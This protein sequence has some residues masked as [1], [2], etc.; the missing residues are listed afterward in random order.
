MKN[1]LLYLAVIGCF[2]F[3]SCETEDT[4]DVSQITNFAV[5]TLEGD[6]EI[7]L[8]VGE[9]YVEP[10]ATAL[11]AGEPVDVSVS[12]SGLFRG[13]ELDVTVPDI[14]S[15]NYSA[16][17]KDGFVATASRTVVVAENGDLVTDLSG[18]YRS[19]IVRN[20]TT[21]PQYTDIEYVLV[22]EKSPGVYQIS[23]A[24]GGYYMYGR[25]Y[26]IGYAAQGLEITVNGP[27]SY[28]FNDPIGVGAF[29]GDLTVT[30]LTTDPINK[31]MTLTTDWSFGYVFKVQLEQV[32]L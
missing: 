27:G 8:E 16:V 30:E 26:G 14:Y 31:T 32:E 1:I 28:S 4:E 7:I 2:V 11:E 15:V 29:G 17:N 5:F 21:G 13:G 19:T 18:L 6:Q 24:I 23:D 10:G 3:T 25:G 9:E 22:W 20:G 12:S